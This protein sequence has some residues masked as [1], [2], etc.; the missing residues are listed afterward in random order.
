VVVHLLE[1]FDPLVVRQVLVAALAG[2]LEGRL[3]GDLEGFR[4]VA[5]LD[6][7]LLL[8]LVVAEEG[9]FAG[10]GEA[11][12]EDTG[13]GGENVLAHAHRRLRGPRPDGRGPLPA[14]R[15]R[16]DKRGRWRGRYSMQNPGPT[17]LKP[18]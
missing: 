3:V 9:D 18:L 1:G 7:Q 11:D 14:G 13:D 10:E 16:A 15:G 8:L 5:V 17:Q 4:V 6:L 2:P 12:G